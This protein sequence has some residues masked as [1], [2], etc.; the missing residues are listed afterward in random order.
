MIGGRYMGSDRAEAFG[1]RNAMPGELL[2]RLRPT[3]IVA[4]H[5]T[6]GLTGDDDRSGDRRTTRG[7]ITDPAG[8]YCFSIQPR[9]AEWDGMAWTGSTHGSWA[10][11]L[12]PGPPAAFAFLRLPWLRWMVL[13]QALVIL[14][15]ILSGKTGN[16]LWSW[17]SVVG[18]TAFMTGAVMLVARFLDLGELE[19]QRNL[20][21]IGIGSGVVAFG[22][23]FGL[24]ILSS[25]LAGWSTTLWLTGPIE[26]GG[27][28]L[29]AAPAAGLRCAAVPGA[30]D[31]ALP[32]PD[33]RRHGRGAARVSSTRRAPRSPGPTW[34]WPC[35]GRRPNCCTCSS[36]GSP[37]RSSGWRRGDVAGVVTVAGVVAFLIAAGIHSF[38]DGIVTFFNVN[39]RSFNS[40]L[41]QSLRD[42]LDKGLG[43]AVFAMGIAA[44]ATCLPGTGHA[45]PPCGD[46]V[47][48][49]PP[50]RPQ[51]KT[52]GCDPK[53]VADPVAPVGAWAGYGQVGTAPRH[54]H[55]WATDRS[56]T[57]PHRTVPATAPPPTPLPATAPPPTPLPATPPPPTDR[58]VRPRFP[59]WARRSCTRHRHPSRPAGT[60]SAATRRCR[61]GGRGPLDP[62]PPVERLQLATDLSP[63][64][65]H[66]DAATWRRCI[67][68]GSTTSGRNRRGRRRGTRR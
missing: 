45:A 26:E 48:C 66:G 57:A 16:A 58:S 42:A 46:I 61:G 24:E 53:A 17:L 27:K 9:L 67:R 37:P 64:T 60:P 8:W 47:R 54:V 34:R 68:A 4:D 52:W 49:P 62:V 63:S 44:L 13:G 5:R 55:R 43:G 31:R 23:G 33:Q 12:L 35:C 22:L 2:V 19:R 41:A 3:R 59:N 28:L 25:Y 38:H 20:I 56:A 18:Y 40:T 50:W 6:L 7:P 36:P 15:A 29:G 1:A 65:V 39:P 21:W 32:G 10:G 11:P 14:P 51:L 30:P